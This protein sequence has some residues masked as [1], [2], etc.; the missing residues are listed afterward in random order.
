MKR[1]PALLLCVLVLMALSPAAGAEETVPMVYPATQSILINGETKE[2]HAYAIHNSNGFATNYV[3][4]RDMAALLNLT[5]ARFDVTWND[6]VD[7]LPGKP[8]LS[9][10]GQEDQAPYQGEQPYLPATADTRVDGKRADIDAF[11]ILDSEGG[12]STYYKLRDLGR[13]LDFSVAWL[14]SEEGVMIDTSIPYQ[15]D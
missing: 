6:G 15:A 5:T 12:G 10:N 3:K 14:G 7:I 4:I 11:V 9:P 2:L 8:Y 13:V 1:Y